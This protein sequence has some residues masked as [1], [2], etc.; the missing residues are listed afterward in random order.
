MVGV[1]LFQFQCGATMV[2]VL[3]NGACFSVCFRAGKEANALRVLSVVS[4]DREKNK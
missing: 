2:V 3:E 4:Y 1:F